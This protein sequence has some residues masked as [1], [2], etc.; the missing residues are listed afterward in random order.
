MSVVGQ[1]AVALAC[2]RVAGVAHLPCDVEVLVVPCGIERIGVEHVVLMRA[3]EGGT[4]VVGTAGRNHVIVCPVGNLGHRS[5]HI[6][7]D[8]V[9]RVG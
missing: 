8:C 6:F 2:P 3:L 5:R 1:G 9:V 4:H 7:A